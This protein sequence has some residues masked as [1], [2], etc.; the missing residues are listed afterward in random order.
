[1]GDAKLAL[2]ETT[3]RI[4]LTTLVLALAACGAAEPAAT[5][6]PD[7]GYVAPASAVLMTLPG[8]IVHDPGPYVPR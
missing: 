1:M 3:M 4:V 8:E 6:Q 5:V 7:G 2:E